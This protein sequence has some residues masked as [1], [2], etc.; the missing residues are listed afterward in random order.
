MIIN[1]PC[2]L[3]R[4]DDTDWI[5]LRFPPQEGAE[6]IRPQWALPCRLLQRLEKITA[7][8]EHTTFRISG[9]TTI[10]NDKPFC[11]L[12]KA[13][14][15]APTTRPSHHD[16]GTK[17]NAD[18]MPAKAPGD[19][20]SPTTQPKTATR[21]ATA[22]Q[23]ATDEGTEPQNR[24]EETSP[25]DI[26]EELLG[27]QHGKPVL[28]EHEDPRP[29]KSDESVAPVPDLPKIITDR[30]HLVV[31]RLVTLQRARQGRWLKVSFT[32]DNTLREPPLRLLPCKL[33]HRAEELAGEPHRTVKLRVS[34]R[35]TRYKGRRYLLL[36]K[37]IRVREMGQF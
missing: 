1:R 9:E 6:N 3:E 5:L 11:L 4:R 25:E 8:G 24:N 29:E 18:T 21:P 32:G 14:I 35:V 17:A 27:E 22:T 16:A 37:V 36:R 19:D 15:L 20:E 33:L 34:G 26:A 2:R 12:T 30:P 10:Y 28:I 13:T 23:S 7:E 31:D